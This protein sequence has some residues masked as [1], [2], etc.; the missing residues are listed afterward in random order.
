[1]T[2]TMGDIASGVTEVYAE[3]TT[4]T[5]GACEL[6]TESD[7]DVRDDVVVLGDADVEGVAAAVG[8]TAVGT[9]SANASPVLVVYLNDVASACDTNEPC[10]SIDDIVDCRSETVSMGLGTCMMVSLGVP[11]IVS[12]TT[13][14][15]TC[16]H[17]VAFPV[18]IVRVEHGKMDNTT[19]WFGFALA[20]TASSLVISASAAAWMSAV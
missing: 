12:G 19:N 17:V 7:G 15:T 8:E 9:F 11:V 5:S 14:T 16:A 4:S 20:A 3:V 18:A 10:V 13:S 1:M 2:V 6:D